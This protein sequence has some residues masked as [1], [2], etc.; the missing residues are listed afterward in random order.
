MEDQHAFFVDSQWSWKDRVKSKLFPAR[1]CEL[2]SAPA[3]FKDCIVL[4][5]GI[6]FSFLDRL[7]VLVS[8][9]MKIETKIVCE[10]AVGGNIASSVAYPVLTH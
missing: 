6:G 7:R 1:Y 5:I 2:Q 3:E 4:K 9:K 10:H 8:G